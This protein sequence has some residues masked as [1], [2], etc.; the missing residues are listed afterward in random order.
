[1]SEEGDCRTA[2]ATP[3]LL[4]MYLLKSAVPKNTFSSEGGHIVCI[5]PLLEMPGVEI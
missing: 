5:E 4:N 2:L 1:M 3:G